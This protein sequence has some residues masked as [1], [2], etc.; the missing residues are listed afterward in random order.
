MSPTFVPPRAPTPVAG[1]V[2]SEK[3][4]TDHSSGAVAAVD[5]DLRRR[6]HRLEAVVNSMRAAMQ[7]SSPATVKQV[8]CEYWGIVGRADEEK[9][10]L[11]DS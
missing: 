3:K 6:V 5:D 10:V 11:N 9:S 1:P 4:Q 2:P 7:D 8:S